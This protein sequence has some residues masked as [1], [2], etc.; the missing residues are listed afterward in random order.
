[1]KFCV[2][3]TID[4]A[5]TQAMKK[6]PSTNSGRGNNPEAVVCF[7]CAERLG[8]GVDKCKKCGTIRQEYSRVLKW[9]QKSAKDGDDCAQERL[10]DMYIKGI[11]TE[12]NYKKALE[13][14][15]KSAEQGN[16]GSKAQLGYMYEQSLGV[17]QDFPKALAL[18]REA[19]EAGNAL[20]QARLGDMYLHGSGIAPDPQKAF[21]YFLKA[22]EQDNDLA[23]LRLGTMYCNGNGVEKDLKK[24]FELVQ[25]SAAQG[26]DR[27]QLLIGGM[28]K[29]G[30][31][32]QRDNK[33]AFAWIQKLAEQGNLSAQN[34]LG[35]LYE[36]GLGVDRD[37]QKARECYLQAAEKG[38]DAAQVSL[39]NIYRRGL[40]VEENINE[41]KKWYV[42]AAEQGYEKAKSELLQI[43][44]E[45]DPEKKLKNKIVAA[46][47]GDAKAMAEVATMYLMGTGVEKSEE[48]ALEWFKKAFEY[49][50]VS[51]R[52]QLKQLQQSLAAK[53]Q[54][55]SKIPEKTVKSAV[56]VQGV[57]KKK[58]PAARNLFFPFSIIVIIGLALTII[59]FNYIKKPG[60]SDKARPAPV[61]KIAEAPQ[62]KIEA[63][64]PAIPETSPET[65]EEIK[66]DKSTIRQNEK[67]SLTI[68]ETDHAATKIE[69]G[70]AVLRREFK[71]LNE[72]EISE[73]LGAKNLFDAERNP[74]G[75]FR[76][77]YELRNVAGLSLIFDRA[78]KLVWMRQQNLVRM[79]LKKTEDWIA[80]LNTVEYGGISKWRLPTVEEAASLL[81]K[82][83]Q[84]EK[85][86]LDAVFGEDIK[87]IWTGDSFTESRSWIIDFRN[88]LIDHAKSKSRLPALMVSSSFEIKDLLGSRLNKEH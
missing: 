71:S 22:A 52:G 85:V 5:H 27:A 14:Y 36:Q 29:D 39:G 10:A 23:Q 26:N 79:T 31:G 13:W 43:K 3:C 70:A 44:L 15:S 25:K 49:G 64:A 81:E 78:T 17:D 11:G 60:S 80:S 75:N 40:G 76:H 4:R 9:Y 53:R 37:F 42:K 45:A 68:A 46:H 84:A 74:S 65:T 8:P 7:V 67:K 38:L 77:Q 2:K 62:Q 6:N 63:V 18:Y 32:V 87:S 73:M 28:Y 48:N 83:P 1:M 69:P 12:R 21:K 24:G 50:N 20:G 72:Q 58:S 86:F 47:K 54:A 59:F 88:G 55:E 61:P 16:A 56:A 57:Q 66:K 34:D 82:N 19:A 33:K 35:H 41:A 51:V 30:K